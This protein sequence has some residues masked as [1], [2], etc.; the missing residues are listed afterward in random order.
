VTKGGGACL[1]ANMNRTLEAP[2]DHVSLA[3]PGCLLWSGRDPSAERPRW[4]MN[5]RGYWSVLADCGTALPSLT[6]LTCAVLRYCL[7]RIP[8]AP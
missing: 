3:G 5:R 8:L 1:S 7:S 6:A 2:L 4:R